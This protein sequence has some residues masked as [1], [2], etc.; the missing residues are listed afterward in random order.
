MKLGELAA[1]LGCQLEGDG[2]ID[3][4]R[5]ATLEQAGAG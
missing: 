5:V 4:T 2:D 1:Q 3:V